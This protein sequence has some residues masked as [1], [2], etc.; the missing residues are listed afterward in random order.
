MLY[1]MQ[2]L[3]SICKKYGPQ[4]QNPLR[5]RPMV[6]GETKPESSIRII[7]AI[8]VANLEVKGVQMWPQRPN[9]IKTTL[10]FEY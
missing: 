1:G 8:I 7:L 9:W 5:S 10:K 3:N 6:A 4:Q 2:I